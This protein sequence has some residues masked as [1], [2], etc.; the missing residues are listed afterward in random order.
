MLKIM[1]KNRVLKTFFANERFVYYSCV[2]TFNN[3]VV[4]LIYLFVNY[5]LSMY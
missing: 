5:S 4:A 2:Y 3:D 1:I